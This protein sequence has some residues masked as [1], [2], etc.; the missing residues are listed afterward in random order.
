M[1]RPCDSSGIRRVSIARVNGVRVSGVPDDISVEEPL[2]ISAGWEDAHGFQTR[3]VAITMRTPGE[4]QNL[5]VGFLFTEGMIVSAGDVKSI[6]VEGRNAV[7]VILNRGVHFDPTLLERHS[8]ISSSCGACGK[9]TIAAVR[10]AQRHNVQRGRP[11][12]TSD[13]I[14]ALPD[15]LRRAQAEFSLTGGIHASALFNSN[16]ELVA[17]R[18]DVGRHNALDKVIGAEFMAGNI[19]LSDQILLV[20]GRISF[21]LVQKAAI[22]GIPVIAAVGAPSSL[23]VELAIECGITL[24]GFVRDNRFNIYNDCGRIQSAATNEV[25]LGQVQ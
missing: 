11:V 15:T 2:Q 25:Q 19:P 18:E 13:T 16:G 14:H 20:S 17:L 10:I 23:A 9:R 8:F 3:T 21:E 22:A 7:T 1:D 5:A 4:D 12:L 6:N 24:L